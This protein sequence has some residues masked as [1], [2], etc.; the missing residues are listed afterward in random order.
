MIYIAILYLAI[1]FR[2]DWL[3]HAKRSERKQWETIAWVL[4]W[5]P[6][7]LVGTFLNVRNKIRG[8][9]TRERFNF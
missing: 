6:V 8:R 4:G 3:M 7:L 5:L 2:L 9:Q 1:G